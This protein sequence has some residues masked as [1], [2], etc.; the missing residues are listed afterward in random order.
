MSETAEPIE[1]QHM[2]RMLMMVAG[3]LGGTGLWLLVDVLEDIISNQRLHLFLISALA[4]YFSAFLALA[5]PLSLRRAGAV[6]IGFGI[7]PPV[8]LFWIGLRH[9]EVS[10]ALGHSY[11][12][13]AFA[14]LIAIGLPFAIAWNL[15]PKGW[16]DYPLLFNHAWGIVVRYLVALV[17]VGLFWGV[18]ILSDAL[19]GMVGITWIDDLLD[20]D[21]VPYLL[22]GGALGLAIAVVNELTDYVSPHL[23]FRLLR[24]LLPV[25]VVVIAVFV[26]ALPIRGLDGVF[27]GLSEATTLMAIAIFALTLVTVALATTEEEAVAGTIMRGAVQ[28]LSL[29]LPIVA[30]LAVYAVWLRVDQYGWTPER[31]LA[32]LIGVLLL[33]YGLAYGA[34][35]LLRRRWEERIRHA[36][37][38]MALVVLLIC[39]AWQTHLLNAERISANSQVMRFVT[40]KTPASELDLWAIGREWGRPGQAAVARLKEM[41]HPEREVLDQRL[42]RL[43]AA[44]SRY[45]FRNEDRR[46]TAAEETAD[47]ANVLVVKPDGTGLPDRALVAL[48]SYER[49]R[50]AGACAR[51]TPEGNAGCIALVVQLIPGSASEE[52][53]LA[54][55]T[56]NDD[57]DLISLVENENGT[58]FA[59]NDWV[60]DDAGLVLDNLAPTALDK[61]H[62]GEFSIEPANL[63]VLRLEDISIFI[64]PY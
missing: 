59:T 41:E 12:P 52:V 10:D 57:V 39:V 20:V 14:M 43:A 54:L 63:N 18:V 62:Q 3:A 4:G 31:L 27:R 25:F 33:A 45:E 22:T 7:V 38:V 46:V 42:A 58:G 8:L 6:A 19:L 29:L 24:L 1:N 40:G 48:R 61:L 17:F 51:R 56:E 15:S 28:A 64:N 34:S 47:L 16:R 26:V 9:D 5:G 35:I 32:M 30:A 49:S 44:S 37:V 55:L 11:G 60:R 53:L 36:N 13:L 50:V 21:V 23:I 2:T